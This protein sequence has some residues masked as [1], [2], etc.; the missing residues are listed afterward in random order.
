MSTYR[1]QQLHYILADILSSMV[2][3]VCFLLFRWLVYEGRIF[4]WESVMIP[5]FDFYRPLYIYPIGCLII[6]YL[7]G[8]YLRVQRK[9]L[10]QEVLTTLI[11]A[12]VIALGAFFAIII[13]DVVADYRHY[14][15]SLAVLF[16]LQF[17]ISY[18]PRVSI[19]LLHRIHSPQP[20]VIII[21]PN[22]L[23]SESDLYR[24]ISQAYPSGKD[25]YIV[26]R[27]IDIVTGAAHIIQ[28][29]DMPYICIT[30]PHMSDCQMSIKRAADMIVSLLIMVI[31]SPVYAVLAIL[32]KRSS[33][34]PVIYRQQRIGL[35]GRSFDILKFRTMVE[36]AESD[37]PQ[38]SAEDDPRV[39]PIGRI[40]RKYRLD[41]LPQMWNVLRGD[42]SL[43]G[44][45]PERAYFIE[46]I[47]QQAPY[48][49][50]LYKIRPG[51]T[52][53]GPI[54]VGYTDTMP[55]MLERLKYDIAYME[56]QSLGLDLKIIF[57][58]LGVI[59]DGKGQ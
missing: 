11:S 8:Y 27:L 45:R 43:V 38:L 56:N 40:M 35:Y 26:P 13:D 19:T 21:E 32:V 14:L 17:V 20:Q 57:Y 23:E 42:M 15:G 5:A 3:W 12:V 53:W 36:H 37:V 28:L 24:R 59:I 25:I 33:P 4:G 48:Y 44:P 9:D 55:K 46:Q 2:V 30:R 39:T 29:N 1:K 51:L 6:Y 49:C 50:L 16:A 52:S 31:A 41:E 22:P 58:T 18:V 10:G 54:K 47:E 34:G 7:S